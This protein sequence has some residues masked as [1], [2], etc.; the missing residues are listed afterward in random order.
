MQE[1]KPVG[2]IGL[3]SREVNGY[4]N[5]VVLTL[6]LGLIGCA[7]LCPDKIVAK[8]SSPDGHYVAVVF[9]RD[10]GATTPFTTEI[11]IVRSDQDA[12]SGGNAGNIFS[13]TDPPD[14]KETLGAMEVRLNWISSRLLAIAT[15]RH[16]S[17]GKRVNQF[18]D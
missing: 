6:L 13:M 3:G 15:T 10:C 7:S 9:Y 2:S 16:A 8:R 17:V 18:G 1:L 11:S 5:A 12:V 14:K 4:L